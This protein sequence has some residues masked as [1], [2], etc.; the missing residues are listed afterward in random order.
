MRPHPEGAPGGTLRRR[1][2]QRRCL[3]R[4]AVPDAC[5]T[6]CAARTFGRPGPH[7]TGTG[8]ATHTGQHVLT[9]E[10]MTA[11]SDAGAL[12]AYLRARRQLVQPADVGIADTGNR[13]VPGLR[14]E[15]VAFL[16][17]V[18]SDYYV[19]LE[20]GRD[21]HPLRTGPAEHRPRLAAG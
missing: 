14:R 16:A 4:G 12:A 6:H 19:R 15:E 8:R 18:S 9:L 7:E 10:R 17:G 1:A 11:R 13:R 21:R 5:L 2:R 20:Q 3:P